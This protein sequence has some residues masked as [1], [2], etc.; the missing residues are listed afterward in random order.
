M[1]TYFKAKDG[2]L[3]TFRAWCLLLSTA[4]KSE[5]LATLREEHLLMERMVLLQDGT[6]R[7]D[8]KGE[9]LPATDRPINNVHKAIKKLTLD[10]AEPS[11]AP[12]VEV[13]YE[14]HA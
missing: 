11:D 10:R 3:D 7:G 12:V 8:S 9:G 5:A 13:L 14:L 6:I 1:S 4:L 2:M